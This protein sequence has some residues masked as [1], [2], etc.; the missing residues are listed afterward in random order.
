MTVSKPSEF[1][2]EARLLAHRL[3]KD[4]K[5]TLR[6][7]QQGIE[8]ASRNDQTLLTFLDRFCALELTPEELG[9]TD[10][11]PGERRRRVFERHPSRS[12]LWVEVSDKLVEVSA[13]NVSRGGLAFR[14]RWALFSGS[15]ILIGREQRVRATVRYCVDDGPDTTIVGAEFEVRTIDDL[16][17]IE[18]LVAS[19]TTQ[20]VGK[21]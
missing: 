6:Q 9:D 16:Q 18:D 15:E 8:W 1:A 13:L 7:L 21:P 5:L 17:D 10:E 20:V 2:R 3:I 11:N 19:L 12:L 4:E 14:S